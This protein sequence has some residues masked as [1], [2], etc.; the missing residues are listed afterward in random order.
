MS[1]LFG[2]HKMSKP[3]NISQCTNCGELYCIECCE[4]YNVAFCSIKCEVEYDEANKQE[5]EDV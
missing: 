3:Y 4:I 5:G 1:S 2:E